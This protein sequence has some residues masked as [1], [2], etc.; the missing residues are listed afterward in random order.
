METNLPELPINIYCEI[1]P[2]TGYSPCLQSII[3]EG[4][5]QVAT[6]GLARQSQI[7]VSPRGPR[8][9]IIVGVGKLTFRARKTIL[10]YEGFRAR[11]DMAKPQQAICHLIASPVNKV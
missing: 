5:K 7:E 6:N 4:G 9:C 10:E 3:N 11:I 8:R 2:W 1:F